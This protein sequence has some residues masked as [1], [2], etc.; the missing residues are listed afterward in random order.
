MRKIQSV[1]FIGVGA[2][3][4]VYSMQL[5]NCKDIQ[6]SVLVEED[7]L[8]RYRQQDFTINNE[9]I[10]FPFKL[11]RNQPVDLVIIAVKNGE[12][13]EVIR[14]IA[15]V[16]SSETIILSLLNGVSSEEHLRSA[17]P[18]SIVLPCMCIGIDAVRVG[19]TITYSNLG[20]IVFGDDTEE[21]KS[22]VLAVKQVFDNASIPYQV[23]NDINREIWWKFMFNVGINQTSAI[24]RATYQI[25]QQVPSARDW[26]EAAMF[27]V[28]AIS[29]HVGVSL[30]EQ[31]VLEFREILT[32]FHPEGKTSM[33]QD[34]E[35][36]RQTE[37]EYFAGTV[38][39]LGE[40]Y[41]VAT[42]INE[43]LYAIIRT[44]DEM[45]ALSS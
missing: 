11:I 40:K 29:K 37:V 30:T 23:S 27:E 42:P 35:Q 43:Q 13:L 25:F 17:F 8:T 21:R 31:D 15:P 32:R 41:G 3:G 44:I 45:N 16:V 18:Q 28:V 19:T 20:K 12:L 24:L 5:A 38:C 33:L 39:K 4:A 36:Q 9:N 34:V 7:R 26:M 10:Q 2:I 22:E 6:F 1:A 14:Q